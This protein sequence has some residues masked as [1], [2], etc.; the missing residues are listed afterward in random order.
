MATGTQGHRDHVLERTKLTPPTGRR[1][2]AEGKPKKNFLCQECQKAFNSLEKLKVHSY[3]HTGER[4]Y[5]P[6][7]PPRLHQGFRLQIQAATA[8][9][10]SLARKK[11][12]VFI[13]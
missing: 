11:P 1:R 13:L 2:R 4:P 12:Q 5:L 8:Y 3:S 10:N 6:L 9:G 7:L